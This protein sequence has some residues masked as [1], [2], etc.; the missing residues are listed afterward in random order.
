MGRNQEKGEMGKR[1]NPESGKRKMD[2]T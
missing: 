1:G 2:L